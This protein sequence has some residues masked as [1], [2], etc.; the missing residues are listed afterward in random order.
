MVAFWNT[1][2]MLNLTGPGLERSVAPV[3]DYGRGLAVASVY[4]FW[5]LALLA[6]AGAMTRAARMPPVTWWACP[7][8]LA[9]PSAF[10]LGLTRYRAPADPYL[11]MLAAL[12][13]LALTRRL[14][15]RAPISSTP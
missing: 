3:W 15:R 11:V 13:L 8:A 7:L 9:L 5:L 4:G 1:V 14:R 2:R 6:I 12:G 10:F